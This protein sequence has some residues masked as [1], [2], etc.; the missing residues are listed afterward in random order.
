MPPCNI[1][2]HHN[3]P[4]KVPDAFPE[5]P[6]E[7]SPVK[8]GSRRPPGH[9]EIAVADQCLYFQ[10]DRS[11]SFHRALTDPEAP[12][13]FPLSMNSDGFSTLSDHLPASQKHRSSHVDPKRFFFTLRRIRYA[14]WRPLQ[15]R[16]PCIHYVTPQHT[17]NQPPRLPLS[18]VRR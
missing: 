8:I 10:K 4:V 9:T 17:R 14:A 13:G 7:D 11:R 18:H 6:S 5:P 15:N 12:S 16:A 3:P 2:R 1:D